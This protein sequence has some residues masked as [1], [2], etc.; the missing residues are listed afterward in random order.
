L[1]RLSLDTRIIHVVLALCVSGCLAAQHRALHDSIGTKLRQRLSDSGVPRPDK[2][3]ESLEWY[4]LGDDEAG[5]DYL[6]EWIRSVPPESAASALQTLRKYGKSLGPILKGLEPLEGILTQY[7]RKAD[8]ARATLVGITEDLLASNG[9]GLQ[10]ESVMR[11]MGLLRRGDSAQAELIAER[12]RRE[13]DS[14]ALRRLRETLASAQSGA[15]GVD[16]DTEEFL[17]MLRG[18]EGAG[19]LESR[20]AT[21]TIRLGLD[22][23]S[24]LRTSDCQS[25][26]GCVQSVCQP[27][28]LDAEQERVAMLASV[29]TVNLPCALLASE[30]CNCE[31]NQDGIASCPS[32]ISSVNR[33][34]SFEVCIGTLGDSILK[35]SC[36]SKQG[37]ERSRVILQDSAAGA[38]GGTKAGK[39]KNG[40]CGDSLR[41]I[42][43]CKT[44]ESPALQREICRAWSEHF[45]SAVSA[46]DAFD[47]KV[48][49]K[50][51]SNFCETDQSRF[52]ASQDDGEPARGISRRPPKRDSAGDVARSAANPCPQ[53]MQLLIGRR[54]DN[55]SGVCIDA[56]EYPGR[57]SLPLVE[58]SFSKAERLCSLAGK[59]LC[60]DEEWDWGCSGE[61]LYPYGERFDARLCNSTDD[62]GVERVLASTGTFSKCRSTSGAYDMS[63]NAAEW[64]SSQRVRGGSYQD[65][66][67]DA[68]CVAGGARHPSTMKKHI[69]FRCCSDVRAQQSK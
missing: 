10:S 12:L 8:S 14:T 17:V 53:D 20:V 51:V 32:A 68:S 13:L 33:N 6:R 30:L 22:G 24:C 26:L 59:R 1:S 54:W 42:C 47:C 38:V 28:V 41:Q 34:A 66:G 48:V 58:T 29:H 21:L 4:S 39:H 31:R 35:S 65:E 2:L 15:D 64:T 37:I 9:L 45:I 62:R 16:E 57:G 25:P 46:G 56:Y 11:A 49:E 3:V 60:T 61:Y 27:R 18:A 5:K 36:S 63:G 67:N 40:K 23:E 7:G 52:S 43:S 44:Q 69:G 19:R 55:S 50:A